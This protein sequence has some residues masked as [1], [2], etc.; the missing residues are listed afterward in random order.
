MY[1]LQNNSDKAVAAQTVA[2]MVRERRDSSSGHSGSSS[3]IPTFFEEF[4]D[5]TAN[6]IRFLQAS[7]DDIDRAAQR[8]LD[9]LSWRETNKVYPAKRSI[10]GQTMLCDPSGRVSVKARQASALPRPR[11]AGLSRAWRNYARAVETLEDARI[12]LKAT[13][14]EFGVVVRAAVV[15]PVESLSLAD[16][17]AEDL[18]QIINTATTYYP[19]TVSHIYVTA[20]SSVLL[21]HARRALMP[22]VSALNPELSSCVD[23]CLADALSSSLIR[24]G[25]YVAFGLSNKQQQQQGHC[26]ALPGDTTLASSCV[27]LSDFVQRADSTVCSEADEDF[28]S[29]YSDAR[30]T[31]F[32]A[33]NG[34]LRRSASRLSCL[35]NDAS[36]LFMFEKR[37]PF[38]APAEMT[39]V[40][41]YRHN[42]KHR[43]LQA[44]GLRTSAILF[45]SSSSSNG[46]I[47][48]RDKKVDDD[49]KSSCY[50]SSVADREPN[51]KLSSVAGTGTGSGKSAMTTVQLASLQRA[52]LS[53]QRMLGSINDSISSADSRSALAA[54]KS[55]LVQQA[56]V[57]MSTVAALNFGVSL[58]DNPGSSNEGNR[59]TL[60]VEPGSQISALYKMGLQMLALPMGLL[61][62]R[63]GKG[64]AA[65]FRHL[66]SRTIRTVIRRLR[67]MPAMSTVLLLAYKHLRI[68]FMLFWTS[69]LLIWQANAAMVWSNLMSQWKRGLV[70]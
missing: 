60:S 27:S 61:F 66:V 43:P 36:G 40:S 55:K 16:I 46:G 44:S 41:K 51:A 5:D 26:S 28:C 52:V 10:S 13:Y 14:Q 64:L 17:A 20:T 1:Y 15:V 12:A 49:A 9:T 29:V 30:D 34:H 2:R 65:T 6:I 32:F 8:I 21:G 57:L 42:H 50:K 68:Y 22:V 69:A 18:R 56:D 31:H 38:M 67:T 25:Q 24:C 37:P 33:D 19:G 48:S 7:Q 35:S 45:D 11:D 54:T 23:F 47:T 59:G 53:V 4:I 70:F 39:S 3:Y 63:S 58:M 62:G